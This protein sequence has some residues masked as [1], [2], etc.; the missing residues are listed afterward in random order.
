MVINPPTAVCTDRLSPRIHVFVQNWTPDG[1]VLPTPSF[2]DVNPNLL[3]LRS[4]E[5]ASR[6]CSDPPEKPP[7]RNGFRYPFVGTCNVLKQ[8]STGQSYINKAGAFLLLWRST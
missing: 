5:Q 4:L 6:G 1:L 2:P 3:A 7:N 8:P